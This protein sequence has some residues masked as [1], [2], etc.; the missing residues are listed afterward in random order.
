MRALGSSYCFFF[1]VQTGKALH[2]LI[3]DT[4][5][6]YAKIGFLFVA[7]LSL[8]CYIGWRAWLSKAMSRPSF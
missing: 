6:E 8:T 7:V 4:A 3:N 1:G 5:S 2:I